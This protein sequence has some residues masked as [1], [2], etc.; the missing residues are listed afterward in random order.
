MKKNAIP[1]YPILFAVFPVLSLIAYNKFQTQF[2]AIFRPL[3]IVIVF[4][5]L[6]Y[7]GFYLIFKK[8]WQK[9]ALITS[10][11]LILFFSY[12]HVFS[13]IESS[14]FL[15]N[16]IGQHRYIVGG[17]VLIWITA[18]I[19]TI[20]KDF[21][22]EFNQL[23]NVIG[24]I[25]VAMPL[26]QTGWFYLSETIVHLRSKKESTQEISENNPLDYSPDVY[27]II[28]DMYT[29]PDA[30][31]EDYDLDMSDFIGSLEEQGF[32]YADESQS[33]YGETFTSLSTSLNMQLIGELTAERNLT[34]GGAEYSDLVI[35]SEVRSIFE[36]LNYQTIAFSTGYRW[37]ELS[38]AD[39]Y[40][41]IKS[42]DPL[43]A[44]TPF[45][46]LLVKSLIIYPFRGYLYEVLPDNTSTLNLSGGLLDT[47]QTLH[48]E[49]QR[50]VLEILPQIA[51]NKNP[52]FTFAHILIPHPP[53]VFDSDGSILTDPGYYSGDNASALSEAYE[54]DGYKRQVQFIS[55]EIEDIVRQIL[56]NSET[57]PI[58]II[59]GD[60][61]KEGNN[62]S[63]ILN[64][65]YFPNQD[66]SALYPSI[67][68][69][70][71][72]RIV[73][74]QFFDF[75]YPL[76][77]DTVIPLDGIASDE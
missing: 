39:I 35:H 63:K 60:H 65:Y 54:I 29:R 59:Q 20:K 51:E 25:L 21:K 74:N 43:H 6:I 68:P 64:L 16:L 41:Q 67:T 5:A 28:L 72:F 24:I 7:G 42:T 12:G 1:Y 53:L 11:S 2:S 3:V 22:P 30:L 48:V 23:V 17:F 36:R 38:D 69:V 31:L 66:Y 33:N 18:L 40:Y 55:Q 62:R 14:A 57:E 58:I 4:C 47:T 27:Y 73:L 61:G 37:S 34:L 70:N 49:T 52:T 13:L 32:F 44:L 77:E 10:V 9:A 19:L 56:D 26:I 46:L 75:D 45:E 8:N 71:S 15:N 76:K 50:N